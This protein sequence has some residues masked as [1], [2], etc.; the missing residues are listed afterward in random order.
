MWWSSKRD[1]AS[2]GVPRN[3]ATSRLDTSGGGSWTPSTKHTPWSHTP[4][5]EPFSSSMT[6]GLDLME[7]EDGLHDHAGTARAAPQ[8]GQ[9]LPALECGHGALTD[10]ADGGLGAVHRFLPG[11]Q[12]RTATVAFER[13]AD[14]SPGSL[15]GLVGEGEHIRAGHCVDQAVN[16]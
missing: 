9:H 1:V 7:N 12:P 10:G 3:R 4:M 16:T 8:L 5:T 13:C 11:G 14:R 2:P 15:I 6:F